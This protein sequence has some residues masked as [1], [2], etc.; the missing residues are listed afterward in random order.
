MVDAFPGC[1]P[2]GGGARRST[3]IGAE[4]SGILELLRD[5]FLGGIEVSL[6]VPEATV[7]AAV[8]EASFRRIVLNLIINACEAMGSRG[9]LSIQVDPVESPAAGPVVLA[10]RGGPPW[11]R[12]RIID[13]GPGIAPEAMARI[14]DVFFTT[15]PRD[16]RK[17][18]GLGLYTVR[19]LAAEEGIGLRVT[20]ELGSGTLFELHLPVAMP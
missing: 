8:H 13:T 3:R 12:L 2:P 6:R 7:F 20:S 10:P 18:S 11:I 9:R 19:A 17:R 16:T 5:E 4:I 14:F 1:E 15:K